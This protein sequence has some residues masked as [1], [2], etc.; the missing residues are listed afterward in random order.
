MVGA[1]GPRASRSLR[2]G[3]L[4]EVDARPADGA[5]SGCVNAPGSYE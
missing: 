4:F 3:D 5:A 1:A 2:S